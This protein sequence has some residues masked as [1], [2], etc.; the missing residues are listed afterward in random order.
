MSEQILDSFSRQSFKLSYEYFET[1]IELEDK[2]VNTKIKSNLENMSEQNIRDYISSKYIKK[3]EIEI[4]KL[5]KDLV[6]LKGYRCEIEK[7]MD[8][9]NGLTSLAG[10]FLIGIFGILVSINN[11]FSKLGYILFTIELIAL[12]IYVIFKILNFND[13]KKYNKLKTYSNAID[14]L[15]A[16]KEDAYAQLERVTDIKKPNKGNR[17]FKK[18][19]YKKY[20]F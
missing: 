7:T 2:K 8:Y 20:Y 10:S 6:I 5:I 9:Y 4:E 15:E 18:K 12:A 3:D 17:R 1:E 16:I 13:E 14:I 11:E 19:N